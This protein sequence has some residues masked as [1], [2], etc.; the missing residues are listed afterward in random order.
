MLTPARIFVE[1][2]LQQVMQAEKLPQHQWTSSKERIDLLSQKG[3]MTSE[4]R[5]A[6]HYVRQIGNQASN[7]GL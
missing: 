6:L 4:I 7:S 1:N 3:I 2:I 5:D